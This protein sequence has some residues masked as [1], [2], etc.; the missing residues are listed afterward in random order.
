MRCLTTANS[1]ADL[2]TAADEG[3]RA[4]QI[5]CRCQRPESLRCLLLLGDGCADE[6]GDAGEGGVIEDHRRVDVDVEMQFDVT[7]EADCVH[8]VDAHFGEGKHGVDCGCGDLQ[9]GR[10]LSGEP[11][12]DRAVCVHLE[13]L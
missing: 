13:L 8:G 1:C 7:D 2:S 6:S 4:R 3:A 10:E 12:E 9:V 11:A 5:Y